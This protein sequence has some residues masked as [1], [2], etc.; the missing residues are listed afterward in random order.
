MT[1]CHR[2]TKM[3]R[4]N[5]EEKNTIIKCYHG[6]RVEVVHPKVSYS[7][8]DIDFGIGFYLTQDEVMAKKWACNKATSI[9]NCYEL[10]LNGLNVYKF[11]PD[12]EWIYYCIANRF[13]ELPKFNDKEYDVIIGPTAD[14]KLFSTLDMFNDGLLSVDDT[15]KIVNCMNYTDQIAIKNQKAIDNALKYIG[16]KELTGQ[17]RQHYIELFRNDRNEANQKTQELIR[18]IK[19]GGRI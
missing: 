7:R 8:N 13:Q 3:E 17:E 10:D 1:S 5:M 2:G 14:D 4:E 16:S 6:S 12:E 15:I 11:K 9:L 18:K 19:R